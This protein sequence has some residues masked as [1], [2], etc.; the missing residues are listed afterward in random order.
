MLDNQTQ[1]DVHPLLNQKRRKY[2]DVAKN[3]GQS[4]EDACTKIRSQPQQKT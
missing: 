3:N 1:N 2:N 4:E